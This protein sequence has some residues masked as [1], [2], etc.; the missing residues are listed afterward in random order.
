MDKCKTSS[1]GVKDHSC[2]LPNFQLKAFYPPSKRFPYLSYQE[3]IQLVEQ[4]HSA[5]GDGSKKQQTSR[6]VMHSGNCRGV[7]GPRR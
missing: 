7:R 1:G 5:L 3:L 2:E 4:R 6:V